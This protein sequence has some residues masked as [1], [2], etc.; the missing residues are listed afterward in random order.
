MVEE[1]EVWRVGIAVQLKLTTWS[2]LQAL[3]NLH[4][5]KF[6]H[7]RKVKPS[8]KKCRDILRT[9][10]SKIVLLH[11]STGNVKSK[12]NRKAILLPHSDQIQ[13]WITPQWSILTL[14]LYYS[15]EYQKDQLLVFCEGKLKAGGQREERGRQRK[16]PHQALLVPGNHFLPDAFFQVE[17]IEQEDG[18]LT[19]LEVTA[20]EACTCCQ[21]CSLACLGALIDFTVWHITV[22]NC[23]YMDL[24]E[25]KGISCKCLLF[26]TQ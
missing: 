13:I 25:S 2:S 21:V 10:L 20:N 9:S 26:D 22:T 1:N 19:G 18:E 24:H 11:N 8:K 3:L 23:Q 6:Y 17:P 16:R 15:S 7:I 4:N 5:I 14:W 12:R